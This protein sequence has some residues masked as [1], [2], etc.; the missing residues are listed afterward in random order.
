MPMK[1]PRYRK[2][3][4]LLSRSTG[5]IKQWRHD[6]RGSFMLETALG[7]SIVFTMVLGVM[8]FCM[9][10]YTYSVY[11]DATRIG[12]HYAI[13][14]GIDSATCSG[15]SSGCAD[16]SATN[17]QNAV[18]NYV[19][20]FTTLASNVKVTVSYPDSSSAPPSRVTVSVTF[21]YKP[22][23][24]VVGTGPSFSASSSGRIEY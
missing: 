5:R 21:K 20:Q 4:H 3:A 15:P 9:M 14:H 16:S 17:V 1:L 11:A 10:G 12:V 13:T 23:F 8:E 7:I 22:I 19:A 2:M 24:G 18:T 6:E